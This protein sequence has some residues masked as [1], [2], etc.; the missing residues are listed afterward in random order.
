[1][2]ALE[3]FV[4]DVEINLK[5]TIY[6]NVSSTSNRGKVDSIHRTIYDRI[7]NNRDLIS[8]MLL[9]KQ[10]KLLKGGRALSK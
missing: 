8:S 9:Y 3:P 4:V 1:M 10:R 2:T 6:Y 7:L 5:F